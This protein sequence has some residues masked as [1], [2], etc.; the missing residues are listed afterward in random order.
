[1]CSGPFRISII[2]LFAGLSTLIGVIPI[3][4]NIQQ[5]KIDEFI[6]FSLSFSMC[7]MLGISIFDLIPTAFVSL[8]YRHSLVF[9]SSIIVIMFLIIQIFFRVSRKKHNIQVEKG[10]SLYYL[11]IV[12]MISLIIHNIPEGIITYLSGIRSYELCNITS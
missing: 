12:S 9:L 7:V 6:V 5:E 3:C 2:S 11:G 1:M 10:R 8:V 4:L